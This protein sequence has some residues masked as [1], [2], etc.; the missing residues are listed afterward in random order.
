MHYTPIAPRCSES[1][2]EPVCRDASSRGCFSV[3]SLEEGPARLRLELSER[4]DEMEKE[5]VR[6]LSL[7]LSVAA[8]PD[9]GLE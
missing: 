2:N 6:E 3:Q 5:E 1:T 4:I 7:G 9:G 8:M